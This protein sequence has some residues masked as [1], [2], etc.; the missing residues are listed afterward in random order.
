MDE[1][2]MEQ[3]LQ[4]AAFSAE[5]LP[6]NRQVLRNTLLQLQKKK[7]Y[8]FVFLRRVLPVLA[9]LLIVAGAYMVMV[10]DDNSHPGSVNNLGGIW[11][12]YTDN[13]A[14]GKS[15]VWPPASDLCVNRFEKSSPGYG[16]QGYAV[17][18][19][20]TTSAVFGFDFLGV[21]S[22]LGPRTVCPDCQGLDLRKY[23]GV[24]FQVKGSI[25]QGQLWFVLPYES[26]E[27]DKKKNACKSLTSYADYQ[28]NISGYLSESWRQVSLNFR[29]DFQQ[30]HWTPDSARVEIEDVLGDLRQIK[31]HVQGEQGTVV[32][33]WIDELEFY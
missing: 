3:Q 8:G 11:Y 19:T 33:F 1:K 22:H 12:T 31:W 9:L 7:G 21:A 15:S 17:R 32:D 26:S 24:R 14:G 18:I 5:S 16:G 2:K 4:Q 10:V 25:P 23:Q 28:V 20:G 29:S 13:V 6:E 27:Y 30:P